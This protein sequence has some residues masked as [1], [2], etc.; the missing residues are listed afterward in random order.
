MQADCVKNSR[1]IM[2][3]SIHSF[4]L[5]RYMQERSVSAQKMIK[6][7]G[8]RHPFPVTSNFKLD[9]LDECNRMFYVNRLRSEQKSVEVEDD[10]DYEAM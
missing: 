5:N 9:S 2:D 4:I 1:L 6:Q 10:C 8:V 7:T 3:L